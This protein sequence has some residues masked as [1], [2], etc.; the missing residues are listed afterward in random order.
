MAK[1]HIFPF[2]RLRDLHNKQALD[3]TSELSK[4]TIENDLRRKLVENITRLRDMKSYRG[5]RHALGL[6]VRGQ[7]TRTQ[8]YILLS[9][10]SSRRRLKGAK[11]ATAIKLN[12][13]NR[14]G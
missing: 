5:M 1:H 7:R 6:P 2:A 9:R 14:K 13:V 8:V 11:T 4:M 10:Q 3:L 12:R